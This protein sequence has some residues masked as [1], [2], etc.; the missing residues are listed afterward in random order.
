MCVKCAHFS[1]QYEVNM[2]L[3]IYNLTGFHNESRANSI[4]YTKI[5]NPIQNRTFRTGREKVK[6]EKCVFIA[7]RKRT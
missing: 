7:T 2:P 4:Y 3:K 1:G 5:E 6:G